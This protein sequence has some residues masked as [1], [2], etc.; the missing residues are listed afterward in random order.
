MLRQLIWQ[1]WLLLCKAYLKS[2]VY[3]VTVSVQTIDCLLICWFYL[4]LRIYIYI[5]YSC[6]CVGAEVGAWEANLPHKC[7]MVSKFSRPNSQWRIIVRAPDWTSSAIPRWGSDLAGSER[8]IQYEIA[9]I[10]QDH[11]LLQWVVDNFVDR[12]KHSNVS[13]GGHHHDITNINNKTAFCEHNAGEFHYNILQ[14]LNKLLHIKM[15]FS[16]LH[17]SLRYFLFKSKYVC[18][19]LERKPTILIKVQLSAVLDIVN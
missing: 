9:L 15:C 4:M 18:L 7:P 12:L 11:N 16:A 1:G 14:L 5:C 6:T 8:A 17:H 3:C 13:Q 2:I 19:I 10:K